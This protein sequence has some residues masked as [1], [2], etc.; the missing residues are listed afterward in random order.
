MPARLTFVKS[1]LWLKNIAIRVARF[2]LFAGLKRPVKKILLFRTGS[3]GDNVC[4]MPAIVSIR[5]HFADA[6]L[7]ILTNAGGKNLVSLEN[8]LAA[9]YYDHIIDYSGTSRSELFKTLKAAGYDLV[10]ELP[11][12][13]VSLRSEV[14][15]MVFFRMAGIRSGFGWQVNTDFS[16]RRT[17]E[18]AGGFISERERLLKMLQAEGVTCMTGEYPLKMGK[19]K[20]QLDSILQQLSSR[21]I[22]ALVPG[23]KRSQNRY[24]LD[25]FIEL[26]KWLGTKGYSTIVVGGPDDRAMGAT[27]ESSVPGSKSFCGLLDAVESAALLAKC[28][29]TISNDTGPMHLSYAV[30]TP[31]I[32]LFSSRD[33]QEKWFPPS[34]SIALR[35]YNVHCS[36][37]FSETC[38]NNICMQGIPL[39]EVKNAFLKLEAQLK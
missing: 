31:V 37:C 33:F 4:A 5:K 16:F 38:S 22:V 34:P 25:R 2:L 3:I 15:N 36:L 14:R 24:P 21:N 13:Q 6:E 19:T 18:K 11:Q 12:D 23:A 1:S 26:G 8:L 35:N 7:H 28:Q 27:I 10:I 32:G 30:G 29:L 39:D 17:Q 20:L 9:E